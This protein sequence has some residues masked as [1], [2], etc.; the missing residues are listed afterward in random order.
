MFFIHFCIFGVSYS[1]KE[2]RRMIFVFTKETERMI[3]ELV[4]QKD[5]TMSDIMRRALE[6]YYTQEKKKGG[7][8]E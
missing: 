3:R 2:K 6:M 4:E 1:M 7:G 5:L 8:N